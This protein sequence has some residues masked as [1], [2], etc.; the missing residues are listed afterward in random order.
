MSRINT[1]VSALT[2]QRGLATSQGKLNSTLERLSTGLKINRG[3]D[4]PSGLIASESLRSEISGINQAIDNGQRANNVISTAEAAL[5]EVGSLLLNIKGMVVQS[6][7]SGALSPDEVQANQLQVDSAVQSITRISNTTTFAGL[8]LID[9]SLDYLTSG[10]S[11]SSFDSLHINQANFGQATNIPVNVDV[12]TSAQHAEVQF[13]SSAIAKTVTL[14]INGNEGVDTLTFASGTTAGAVMSAINRLQDATGVKAHLI[15]SANPASGVAFDSTG[16]GSKAFVSIKAQSGTFDVT[17]ANGDPHAR[18]TGRDARATINGALT[19]ADGLKIKVATATLDMEVSLNE[20]FGQGQTHFD[21]TGGG[22]L[23]QLGS[24]VTANQQ[25]N[26]GLQSVAASKLGDQK[27]GFLNDL[28]SGGNAALVDGQAAKAS[29]IIEKAISQVATMRGRLG[30]FEKNTLQT[31]MNSQQ[32][33]LENVTASESSI[34][35][36]DFAKETAELTRDQI[37]TQAGTSVLATA[38]SAPQQ[39]LSLLRGG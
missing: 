1:N 17:D 37:L 29:R 10:A 4:D 27:D 21:I 15:N 30:A 14:E 34:R 22:A 11:N 16:W 39:V 26:I 35:D 23:F 5:S 19:V 20:N 13:R 8:R 12:I 3:A 31:N 9:G 38:N 18:D 32:I 24:K 6:A 36:S 7:N 28:V 33:A 25:V 2:A